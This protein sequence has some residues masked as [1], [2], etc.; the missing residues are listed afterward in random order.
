MDHMPIFMALSNRRA[1]VVGGGQL[2]SRKA[3]LLLNAC[4]QVEILSDAV[5]PAMARLIKANG[6]VHHADP[7]TPQHL[8]GVALVIAATDDDALNHAVFD[9]A[10]ARGLPVNIA[11]QPALCSFIL[12]AIVDRAPVTVA[13]STGGRSPVF[14]RHVKA[15]LERA[16]PPGL[17]HAAQWL[18][19]WRQPVR[20]AFT[21][22]GARRR[23]WE[24]I[25][26]G[27]VGDLAH[28][29]ADAADDAIAAELDQPDTAAGHLRVIGVDPRDVDAISIAAHRALTRADLVV[30][31]P[32]AGRDILQLC[33]REA[34]V[35]ELP[36]AASATWI[37]KQVAA[38][39][40]VALLRHH[41]T[42]NQQH[43]DTA[44]WQRADIDL[45]VLPAAP[46]LDP[47]AKPRVIAA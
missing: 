11:D 43:T 5:S 35:R 40:R 42:L 18:A 33:R 28:T 12:P 8:D 9:A 29:D 25:I 23:F 26:D 41:K 27:P 38:G 32:D 34:A 46:T 19:R 16:L 2:A 1:L 20:D 13:V 30:L 14:A 6:L 36:H 21:D 17:G 44:I 22:E 10:S 45:R 39:H 47:T 15:L 24:R 7:F 3:A 31:E 4:P 37:A